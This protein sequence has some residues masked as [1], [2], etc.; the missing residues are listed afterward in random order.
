MIPK[1]FCRSGVAK[2]KETGVEFK[3]Y[4]ISIYGRFQL[5]CVPHSNGCGIEWYN[6][7]DS[8]ERM[9][10]SLLKE[11]D[12]FLTEDDTINR[13]DAGKLERAIQFFSETS[14][15]EVPPYEIDTNF[16]ILA[17]TAGIFEDS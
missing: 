8:I 4:V 16:A 3:Y 5:I 9:N 17:E 14:P 15:K 6:D 11:K 1:I 10:V 13:G 12:K 7:P 2:N